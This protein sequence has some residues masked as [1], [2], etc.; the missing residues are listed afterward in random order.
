MSRD[1]ARPKKAIGPPPSSA[2]PTAAPA[3][4]RSTARASRPAPWRAGLRERGAVS[5][6][7]AVI[8]DPL[9]AL[10]QRDPITRSARNEMDNGV[11]HYPLPDS[12][13][14]ARHATDGSGN[15]GHGVDLADTDGGRIQSP[16]RNGWAF[17]FFQ[18]DRVTGYD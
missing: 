4:N 2:T 3:G 11:W 12:Q 7:Q 13:D 5:R 14:A 8:T 16:A 15:H 17:S 10:R 9:A 6:Q 18:F 1:G